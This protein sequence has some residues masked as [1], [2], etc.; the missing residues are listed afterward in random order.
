[1]RGRVVDLK[2]AGS[3][4]EGQTLWVLPAVAGKFV[5]IG[6]F[7]GAGP[8]SYTD[9]VEQYVDAGY[10]NADTVCF[11]WS[12]TDQL[13]IYN[14]DRHAAPTA[15]GTLSLATGS[16]YNVRAGLPAL[17]ETLRRGQRPTSTSHPRSSA[18]RGPHREGRSSD[19]PSRH[20][21][22]RGRLGNF[23]GLAE[24]RTFVLTWQQVLVH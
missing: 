15:G 3:V 4:A 21:E 14:L 22:A 20:R 1:M 7:L 13:W 2:G 12:S 19:R 24:H 16:T 6:V 11:R 18:S 17:A 9:G 8:T 23:T 10:S 5:E